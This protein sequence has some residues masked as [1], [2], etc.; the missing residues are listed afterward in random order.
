MFE[1]YGKLKQRR[2]M[3]IQ[4]GAR[5]NYIY[6]RQLEAAGL[7]H[8]LV[9]DAAWPTGKVPLP[10][11][12]AERLVPRFAGP[13]A[14]RN[15]RG[16][17][18][19][20]IQASLLPNAASFLKY[21]VSEEMAFA[22]IDEVLATTFRKRSLK[23]VDVIVNYLGNGGSFLKYAKRR[24]V[25]I[26]TDFIS[27]PNY[28][29]I[30]ATERSLW[31]GWEPEKT[32]ASNNIVYQKRVS[33]LVSLSDVYLCPSKNVADALAD[34]PGFDVSRVRTV[35]Y[36]VSGVKLLAP[37]TQRGRVLLAASV[38]SVTKGI[39]YLA[40]AARI[41]KSRRPEVEIVVA[42]SASAAIRARP[43]TCDLTF[44]GVLDRERMA[45]EFAKADI[46][47]LPS[48]AEGSAT[49]IFEAMAFSIPIVTTASSGS[50]VK[51]GV[52]GYIV[53]ER[54]GVAI[55]NAIM[56]I[57]DDRGLRTAMSRSA[58]ETA[59]RYS[60]ENCGTAFVSVI[61][62]LLQEIDAQ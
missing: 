52:E 42:G 30:L 18:P 24:G 58:M 56:R 10:V 6:A 49:V 55:A 40:Q 60:D 26:A 20:R 44:L 8:S 62:E 47:C 38:A 9:C 22:L 32:S 14:R 45:D 48:L 2:V 33:D 19:S 28:W 35:P 57:V 31:P 46:F 27:L 39:P 59:A 21:L 7:L 43:E 15:V 53:P 50:V 1:G 23:G 12:L 25:K 17:E 61:R 29:E 54:D 3:M 5:R 51:D 4:Q 36:G 16:I 37:R 41:L 13:V 34:I 11:K